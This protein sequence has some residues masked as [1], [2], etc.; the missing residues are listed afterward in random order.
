MTIGLSGVRPHAVQD[1]AH[2]HEQR[3][4]QQGPP[5]TPHALPS[6]HVRLS[7]SCTRLLVCAAVVSCMSDA[8]HLDW[9]RTLD[10]ASISSAVDH[11][12]SNRRCLCVSPRRARARWATGE[13]R[14]TPTLS[15][16][17]GA[18]S[19][20]WRTC[21][22]RPRDRAGRGAALQPFPW[23]LQEPGDSAA[24]WPSRR[25]EVSSEDAW[26]PE[27][28]VESCARD[29]DRLVGPGH[30]DWCRGRH[31]GPRDGY[32]RSHPVHEGGR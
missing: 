19:L 17:G 18:L 30:L 23:C 27:R 3:G 21:G 6:R 7:P 20:G 16:G 12:G 1:A 26:R 22:A 24:S 8:R 28:G 25:P 4:G 9:P 29:R 2:H 32:R 5:L 31:L 11:I 13:R 14:A 15:C 10:P